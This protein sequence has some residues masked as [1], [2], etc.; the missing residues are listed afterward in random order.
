MNEAGRRSDR[1]HLQVAQGLRNGADCVY[2]IT[3]SALLSAGHSFNRPENQ[4]WYSVCLTALG[5]GM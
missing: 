4:L 1:L 5:E 3:L 2:T